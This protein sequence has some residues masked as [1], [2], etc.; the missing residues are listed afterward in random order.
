MQVSSLFL[1]SLLLL[2]QSLPLVSFNFLKV[3][4]SSRSATALQLNRIFFDIEEVTKSGSGPDVTNSL[5]L[6]LNESDYRYKHIKTILKL[7]AGD[8]LKGFQTYLF[9]LRSSSK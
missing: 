9:L 1:A 2:N 5:I 8:T 6:N 4:T 3:I 7:E